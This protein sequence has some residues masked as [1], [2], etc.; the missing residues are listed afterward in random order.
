MGNASEQSVIER[1]NT[2]EKHSDRL[3]SENR[4]LFE[5]LSSVKASFQ[6]DERKLFFGRLWIGII[7][8]LIASL[9]LFV[10][11]WVH[12]QGKTIAEQR[13]LLDSMENDIQSFT[14]FSA[15]LDAN[16]SDAMLEFSEAVENAVDQGQKDISVYYKEKLQTLSSDP[17]L[18]IRATIKSVLNEA[19][20]DQLVVSKLVTQQV[21]IVNKDG[22]TVG[23]FSADIGGD[24]YFQLSDDR[25][26]AR[27]RLFLGNNQPIFEFLSEESVTLLNMGIFT[28]DKN[29]SFVRLF[30]SN[31]KKGVDLKMYDS[32]PE[33][34][35]FNTKT[36]KEA[37]A[38]RPNGSHGFGSY[39][40]S[41]SGELAI[42]NGVNK[43]SRDGLIQVFSEENTKVF[44]AFR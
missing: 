8:G 7:G 33:I 44:Q 22:T 29:H 13:L 17:N 31:G 40:Y 25:G 14:D 9:V 18:P 21:H 3:E 38:T 26:A 23:E 19:T 39:Y 27:A 2:L 43:S 20:I 10:A 35:L 1:L 16:F 24:G 41:D 12:Q 5:Q 36:Q 28:N 30:S 37:Y 11:S 34:R 42:F 32:L 15:N 4:R 6:L